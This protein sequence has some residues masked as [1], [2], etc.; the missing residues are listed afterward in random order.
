MARSLYLVP[1]LLLLAGSGAAQPEEGKGT[2][3]QPYDPLERIEA[4]NLTDE[5]L[6]PDAGTG[7]GIEPKADVLYSEFR[8]KQLD[9]K[10]QS[11]LILSVTALIAHFMVLSYFHKFKEDTRSRDLVTGT[12]LVYVIFGTIILTQMSLNTQQMMAATGILGAVAGYLFGV[13]GGRDRQ[14]HPGARISTGT[15]SGD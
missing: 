6:A 3:D 4:L 5:P 11:I 10:L 13:S 2:G 8:M 14:P 15:A 12:G 9:L 7:D 1:L